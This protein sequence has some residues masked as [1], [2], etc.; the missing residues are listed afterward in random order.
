MEHLREEWLEAL[1]VE[2][3][4][5]RKAIEILDGPFPVSKDARDHDTCLLAPKAYKVRELREINRIYFQSREGEDNTGKLYAYFKKELNDTTRIDP[6]FL[7]HPAYTKIMA[8]GKSV[9]PFILRDLEKSLKD[10]EKFSEW[11]YWIL[12]D[13]TGERISDG[14]KDAVRWWVEWGKEKGLI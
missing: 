4:R 6:G 7:G 3:A 14:K 11:F 8:L 12:P 10:S 5:L 2:N 9:V 13:L 1:Q